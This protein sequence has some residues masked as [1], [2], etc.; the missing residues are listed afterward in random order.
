M[1]RFKC[2]PGASAYE[3][4]FYTELTLKANDFEVALLHVGINGILKKK[5]ESRY[6]KADIG[7]KN[8][9]RELQVV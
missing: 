6:W 8:N 1:R 7:Y 4:K 2:I 5:I 9:Y 3:M